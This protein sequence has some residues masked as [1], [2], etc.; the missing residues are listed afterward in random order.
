MTEVHRIRSEPKSKDDTILS[1]SRWPKFTRSILNWSPRMIQSYHLLDDQSSLDHFWT[2]VLGWYNP[3]SFSKTEVSRSLLGKFPGMIPSHHILDDWSHRITSGHMSRD[4]T[5]PLHSRRPRS[6]GHFWAS[7]QGWYNPTAT[8]LLPLSGKTLSN[9][10][11]LISKV[12]ELH[13][14]Q[15]FRQHINN[16][17]ISTHILELYGSFLHNVSNVE[18][19]NFYVL[20]S[21]VEHRVLC[22]IYTALVV[23]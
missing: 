3:S 6:P 10:T 12:F 19:P 2:Y 21:V 1:P 17:F 20:W 11:K 7:A 9:H 22:H 16:L 4:D 8:S 18:I 13:S 5:I 15:R 14:G 23:T